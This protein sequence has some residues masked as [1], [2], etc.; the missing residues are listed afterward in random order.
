MSDLQERLAR[1]LGYAPER[2]LI[3]HTFW[4]NKDARLGFCVEC[5]GFPAIDWSIVPTVLADIEKRGWTWGKRHDRIV[6][7]GYRP[8]LEAMQTL[9]A[10]VMGASQSPDFP[11]ALVQAY[12]E[13]V[14]G[15]Q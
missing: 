6:T 4:A 2:E 8:D 13:A 12:V 7:I 14:E 5:D 3:G 9:A 1:A 11:H 10:T 15:Q